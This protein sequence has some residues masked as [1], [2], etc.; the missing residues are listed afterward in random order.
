MAANV[1]F[2]F[3]ASNEVPWHRQGLVIKDAPTSEDAIRIARLD[4]DVIQMPI[5]N[6]YGDPIKGYK[7]NVRS[8]DRRILGIVTDRYKIVQNREAFAFTDALIGPHCRFETAGSLESGKKVWLLARLDNS[9]ICEEEIAPYLVFYNSHDGSGAIRVAITP[10]RVVCSNTLNLALTTA[11]RQWS[12]MHKGNIAARLDEARYTLS[13]A[14]RYM[15][16]L[17]SEFG[18]LKLKK[19]S[20]DTVKTLTDRLVNIEFHAL[21]KKAIKAKKH[22]SSIRESLRQEKFEEKLVR[23]KTD[24]L[25]IYHYK[26]DLVGTERTAFRFI[27]AVSDYAGHTTDHKNTRNYDTNLFIKLAD[28]HSL[29]DTA[30]RLVKAA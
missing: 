6:N 7:A 21:Y 25:N 26:S 10:V 22:D 18:E 27:N 12:C 11:Q 13:S 29:I 17:E 24:I 1:E 4:W 8:T 19:L 3:S 16:A 5:Y 20:D 28:G 2:M 14:E 30:Y 23:K 15:D 9:T